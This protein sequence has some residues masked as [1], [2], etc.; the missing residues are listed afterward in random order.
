MINDTPLPDAG[1]PHAACARRISW[2]A[3]GFLAIVSRYAYGYAIKPCRAR[4]IITSR[5][6]LPSRRNTC[7]KLQSSRVLP[8]SSAWALAP[9]IRT[10]PRPSWSNPFPRP[11]MSSLYRA[12]ANT[13]NLITPRSCGTSCAPCPAPVQ[14]AHTH[15]RFSWHAVISCARLGLPRLNASGV[16]LSFAASR[17]KSCRNLSPFSP[18]GL[19]WFLGLV[20]NT[21]HPRP[22]PSRPSMSNRSRSRASNPN[23]SQARGP[24][25]FTR[26]L[27]C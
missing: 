6:D 9:S 21:R 1:A 13:T 15:V 19:S 25:L 7:L 12:K 16:D 2:R 23:Y 8:L 10:R 22:N 20:P 3:H 11:S 18:S 26:A 5:S 4:K 14:G 24:A 27:S 17:S